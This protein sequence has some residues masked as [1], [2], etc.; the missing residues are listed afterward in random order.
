MES[1]R[2]HQGRIIDGFTLDELVHTGGMASLWRVSKAGE[3]RP[4]LMKVP[5]LGEGDDPSAIIGF[6]I[7][8]MILPRLSG[9]HVPSV[10]SVGDFAVLPYL[11]IERLPGHSL[12]ARLKQ[13]PLPPQDV[14]QLGAKIATALQ[15]IHRQHVIHL[16]VKPANIML[17]ESGTAV[18]IDFGL[19]RHEEL[20]DLLAEESDLPIGTSAYMAPEQVLG[21][22]SD[23]RSDIFSLGV[24]L[25]ELLTGIKPFGNPSTRAGMRQ[26]LYH[27]P[28]PLRALQPQLP[29]WVQEIILKCME[30]DPDHRYQSAGQLAHA[31]RNPDQVVLTERAER[32]TSPGLIKRVRNWWQWQNRVIAPPM[33][34]ADRLDKAAIIMC[35]LDFSADEADVISD[36]VKRLVRR[37]LETDP[38]ARLVCLTILKTSLVKIDETLD[39]GGRNI[40]LKR[41][42]A[43]KEW[44]RSLDLPEESI[45]FHVIEAVDPA[46]AILDYAGFNAVDHIVMGARGYSKLR[47]HLGSVSSRVVAEASCSVTVVRITQADESGAEEDEA[48]SVT[49]T[50]G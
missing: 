5:F 16:D 36:A 11:V 33:R 45:S 8:H 32:I 19:A 2:L 22:R 3:S 30:V 28:K 50:G 44:A 24:V 21:I 29:A 7:E 18:M 47:R 27:E 48:A 10:V 14:C 39:Q 13:A 17:R 12:D 38:E 46:Q 4:M 15:D 37:L 23:P 41:L 25:Y 31:L 42:V 1:H 35:A 34:I 6:E 43:M 20:P 9:Q 40:Y 26:R 49:G